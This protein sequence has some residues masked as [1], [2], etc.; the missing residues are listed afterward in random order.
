MCVYFLYFIILLLITLIPR[1]PRRF[2]DL[3][4]YE[5]TS[6]P[7]FQIM[8]RSGQARRRSK[9]SGSYPGSSAGDDG[10]GSDPEPSESGS[11]GSRSTTSKKHMTIAER[12]AAYQE[13]RTR[14]F[15]DYEEKEK[16]KEKNGSASSSS[17]SVASVSGSTSNQG[18]VDGYEEYINPSYAENDDWSDGITRDNPHGRRGGYGG[19][20]V[21]TSRNFRNNNSF[22]AFGAGSARG[23]GTSSPAITFPNI[24]EQPQAPYDP[25][26][27]YPPPPLPG[28]YMAPF[29]MYP[30]APPGQ[31]PPQPYL[32]PYP[33]YHQHYPY[34]PASFPPNQSTSSDS[35]SPSSS[36]ADMYQQQPYSQMQ[37]APPYMW[38]HTSP[39]PFNPPQGPP[40]HSP[41]QMENQ[42]NLQQ[43]QGPPPQAVPNPAYPLP[44]PTQYPNA[45]YGPYMPPPPVPYNY[46][47]PPFY[48]QQPYH[49]P[50]PALSQS[51]PSFHAEVLPQ[52]E[53]HG[54]NDYNAGQPHVNGNTPRSPVRDRPSNNNL[55]GN[56][57][58]P[59]APVARSAWSYG[60]GVGGTGNLMNAP[61]Y[62]PSGDN[63]GPR[64]NS[65]ARRTSGASSGSGGGNRPIADETSSTTVRQMNSP[66][67]T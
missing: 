51:Q 39:P 35:I 20:S 54:G 5:E 22:N 31:A 23:S 48:G 59:S 28:G 50:P 6:L 52:N 37:F 21:G 2:S 17:L 29:P 26:Q 32:P 1:P 44:P 56:P 14:I 36:P 12:E 24:Y 33:Y 46:A 10:E 19:S 18:S 42:P 25:S 66:V 27:G 45:P 15:M 49:M 53:L 63:V 11:M 4:P 13:A 3:V 62:T 47:V 43:M 61:H 67:G 7:K 57:S 60:P 58:R 34:P 40:A 38:P 41:P 64:F 16:S 9:P 65:N 55:E 8:R 30:Y